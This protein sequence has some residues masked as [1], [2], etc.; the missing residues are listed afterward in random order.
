MNETQTESL[1]QTVESA[2]TTGIAR[3]RLLRAGLAAA[4]VLAAMKSNTVLA[5]DHTCIKPSSF[6]SL[7]PANWKVSRGRTVNTTY[8]CFSHGHWKN[9]SHPFPYNDKDKSLFQGTAQGYVSALFDATVFPNFAGKTL[10]QVLSTGGGGLESL[11]RHLV[12]SFLTAVANENNPNS[13]LITAEQCKTIWAGK[14]A[15]TPAA[16]LNWTLD[17]TMA[18]FD[19]IYGAPFAITNL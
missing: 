15:W 6:S 4:P 18:Y 10:Q 2:Q 16:G 9:H 7:K 19:K 11:A 5:G 13:V 12:G 17:D 3:R 14:G 1:P 8:N